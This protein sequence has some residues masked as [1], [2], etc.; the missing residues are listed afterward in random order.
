[1][2]KI[3]PMMQ[4]YMEIKKEH[5]DAILFFRLGDFYEMFW[6]DASVASRILNLTLTARSEVPMCGIPYHASKNY[7]KRLLDHGKKIAICEQTQLAE[8]GKGIAKREVVQIISPG[9]IIEEDYLDADKNN[10]IASIALS[11]SDVSCSYTD[12]STGEFIV[13]TVNYDETFGALRTFLERIQPVELLIQESL[14]FENNIF[15]RIIDATGAMIT[16]Y[17]DWEYDPAKTYIELS[18]HFGTISLKSFGIEHMKDP[19]LLSTGILFNY[20]KNNSKTSLSH[21]KT[22]QKTSESQYLLIDDSSQKNLEI[23]TNLHDATDTYTLFSTLKHTKTATGT[24]LLRKWLAA[25]LS[26]HAAI[27]A[28]LSYTEAFYHDPFQL[29]E[30]R[31][32]LS[33]TRDLERLITRLSLQK[34]IPNDLL[35]IKQTILAAFSLISLNIY[36]NKA[37]NLRGK[38]SFD[39]LKSLIDE[40]EVG[41]KPDCF[42][43]FEEGSV[44]KDAYSE[45]LDSLRLLKDNSKN[46][47][48]NY[49]LELKNSTGIQNIKIKYNKIIGYYLEISKGQLKNIPDFFIRKQTLVNGERFTTEKLIELEQRILRAR[50]DAEYVERELY[51]NIQ[52]KVKAEIPSL[53]LLSAS[54]SEIDCYQSFAYIAVKN[55]YCKPQLVETDRL[56]IDQGRHPVVEQ[57]LPPGDFVP[58]NYDADDSGYFYLITGPNMAGKS[59]YLRQTALIVLMAHIGSF[60]PAASAE[61][62]IVDRIFCRVGATD[63][64]ARGESTFLVEMSETAYILRNAT[65]Q[66]LIIMDEVGRGTSTKDGI[67]L[68]FAVMKKLIEM[69]TKTLFATHYHELTEIHD[70]NIK[71]VYLDVIESNGEIIFLKK[72]KNGIVTSSYGLHAAKLAGIPKDVLTLAINYQQ[73]SIKKII[74]DNPD[75]Y[76]LFLQDLQSLENTMLLEEK[77]VNSEI[78]DMLNEIIID[79]TTPLEALQLLCK[80]KE[81][82]KENK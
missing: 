72:V 78:I 13:T 69:G 68:A 40:I 42:G 51:E 25:P 22:I 1:M 75:Q 58:N 18:E 62:G 9:T 4:Q 39:S 71:K 49:L 77:T 43:P 59:T 74:D 81:I 80:I 3:T 67:A 70:K 64:L 45:K 14:Y 38:I 26:S 35:L 66:S 63:N 50:D 23:L 82:L 2:K 79:N 76:S 6:E 27:N 53:I 47:L 5:T 8:K 21:I 20:I 30:V 73:K 19:V 11:K 36:Q 52:K 57:N 44:I 61:I 41:I 65:K 48:N 56:C 28:R 17:Q 24:R 12:I 37:E 7:I 32:I 60:V 16:R 15:Q 46:I 10:Y 31:K 29:N 55:G 54:I 34:S 33:E